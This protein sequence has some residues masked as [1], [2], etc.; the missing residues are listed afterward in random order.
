[1]IPERLSLSRSLVHSGE[2]PQPPTSLG[3]MFPFFLLA[4]RDFSPFPTPLNTRSCSPLGPPIPFPSLV[5]PSPLVVVFFSFPNETEVSSLGPFSLLTFQSFVGCISGIL[6]QTKNKQTNKQ[7]NLS[8][9]VWHISLI[10]ALQR[11]VGGSLRV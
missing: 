3:H 5:T 8:W 9:E 2:S 4:L 6:K 1:M 10:P 11:Q 7:T